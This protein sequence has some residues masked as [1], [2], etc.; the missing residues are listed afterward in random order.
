MAPRKIKAWIG[1]LSETGDFV[2]VCQ[3]A[4]GT[5]ALTTP[6]MNWHQAV[7]VTRQINGGTEPDLSKWE[8][9]SLYK[10]AS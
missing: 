8:P 9:V 10:H 6:V 1:K 3:T 5:W 7:N 2:P 4:A